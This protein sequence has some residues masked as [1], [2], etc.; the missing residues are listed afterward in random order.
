MK[1]MKE[2]KPTKAFMQF[3]HDF[4]DEYD[5]RD[6]MVFSPSYFMPIRRELNERFVNKIMQ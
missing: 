2:L 6:E 4:K 3:M 5:T 1:K